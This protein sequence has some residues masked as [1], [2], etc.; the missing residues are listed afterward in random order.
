MVTDAELI[1]WIV[2]A[3]AGVIA[4]GVLRFMANKYSANYVE[5]IAEGDWE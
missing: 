5:W 2:A 1:F 4:F 3:I